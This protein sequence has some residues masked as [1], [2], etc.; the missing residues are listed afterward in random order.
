MPLEIPEVEKGGWSRNPKNKNLKPHTASPPQDW[1]VWACIGRRKL[2]FPPTQRVGGKVSLS[3]VGE[4]VLRGFGAR[5]EPQLNVVG[6][7]GGEGLHHRG[8]DLIRVGA[9]LDVREHG[10]V[11]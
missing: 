2:D 5:P 6:I 9:D 8:I 7:V 4:V 10:R 1:T 3:D 11:T